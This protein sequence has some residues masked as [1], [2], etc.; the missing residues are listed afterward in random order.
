MSIERDSG[1]AVVIPAYNEQDYIPLTLKGLHDQDKTAHADMHIVVDNGSTDNT[2][3]SI[4][5]FMR[6]HEG[7][8][9]QIIEEAAKGTGAAADTGFR[10]AIE[11]GHSVVARTD[12]DT[13]PKADWVGRI[14]NAFAN[15]LELQLLS[16]K[17]NALKDDDHRIGDEIIMPFAVHAARAALAIKNVDLDY[18]R[19]PTGGNMATR[20]K[21]YTTVD[22]FPR[23]SIDTL[24]EDIAYGLKV[25]RHFGRHA[26]TIDS[27][28]T[29]AT[30][31]RRIRSNGWIGTS[32]HHL[33]PAT[34]EHS[35]RAIDVR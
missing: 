35:T 31:M 15:N 26:I 25:A 16:G 19:V 29:V 3:A 14:N 30:S 33:F 22:G 21:A 13:V 34:R 8:P 12:A 20:A 9:L 2:M 23:T 6:S 10:W 32:L 7:F 27:R 5:E 4:H 17:I 28:L 24:D 11:H 1:L 18:L